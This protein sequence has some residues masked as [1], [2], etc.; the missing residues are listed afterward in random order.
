MNILNLNNDVILK[1]ILFFGKVEIYTFSET[2]I[3]FYKIIKNNKFLPNS[4]FPRYLKN[5]KYLDMYDLVI[6]IKMIEWAKKHSSFKYS[7]RTA[8]FASRHGNLN[9]LKYLLKDKCEFTPDVYYEAAQ[10]GY[11][12]I[13]KWCYQKNIKMKE[14]CMAQACGYGDIKILK[15]MFKKNFPYNEFSCCATASYYGKID[16]LN[17]LIKEKYFNFDI[18]SFNNAAENGHINIL[19]YLYM[20]CAHDLSMPWWNEETVISACINNRLNTIKFLHKY[21][22]RITYKTAYIAFKNNNYE[23]LYWLIE[24]NC[25]IEYNLYNELKNNYNLKYNYKDINIITL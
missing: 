1:I 20:L 8:L 24:N 13:I 25:P 22:C 16:I 3:L 2:C 5:I 12:D 19:K 21:G 4:L 6:S 9:T 17:F 15:W 11:F 23:I 18:S 10:N 7:Y 14:S